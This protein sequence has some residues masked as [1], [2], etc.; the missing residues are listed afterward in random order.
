MQKFRVF[1]IVAKTNKA[2]NR[3]VEAKGPKEAECSIRKSNFG[4]VIIRKIKRIK[5]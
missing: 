2:E 1:Y 3:D 4:I 5:D